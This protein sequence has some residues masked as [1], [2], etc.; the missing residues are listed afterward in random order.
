MKN[1]K[2]PTSNKRNH[3]IQRV[4]KHYSQCKAKTTTLLVLQ[5]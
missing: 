4:N 3:P 5:N 1:E 2:L